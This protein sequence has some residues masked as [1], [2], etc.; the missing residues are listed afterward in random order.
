M[1]ESAA[2]SEVE[3]LALWRQIESA[4]AADIARRL[5]PPGER[6]PTEQALAARFGVNRHT[7][8]RAMAALEARG[9]VR[10]EQGRGSFV[11][12]PVLDYAVGRHTRF[13]EIVS[14]HNRAPGHRLLRSGEII[15]EGAVARAL[16]LRKGARCLMMETL[17]EVDGRPMSLGTHYLPAARFPGIA[18][19]YAATQSLSVA[20]RA[21]GVT[22]YTRQ[23]TRIVARPSTAEEAAQLKQPR[24]RPVLVT[25][26]IDIDAALSP[27]QFVISRFAADRVQ[28]L[29]ES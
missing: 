16:G 22:D 7:L 24:N 20:L 5:Y 10:I 29:V 3:G 1:T 28:I 25:E 6:L 26:S 9:L 23:S 12:D 18:E 11:Q 15:V 19:R 27:I 17:G 13:S 14:R 2:V 8:R 21:Y 4:I